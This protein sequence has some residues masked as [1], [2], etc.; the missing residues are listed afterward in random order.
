MATGHFGYADNTRGEKIHESTS[1]KNY[2]SN[3][4]ITSQ[5][6]ASKGP[7]YE[8]LRKFMWS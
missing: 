6:K 4:V 3:A 2:K 5:T 7:S 8:E 1:S